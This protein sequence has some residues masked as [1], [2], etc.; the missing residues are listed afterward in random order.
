MYAL[1]GDQLRVVLVEGVGDEFDEDET[2]GDMLVFRRVHIVAEFVSGA[3]ELGFETVIGRGV[4]R[5]DK[6]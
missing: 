3:P 4:L 1:T 2:E 5:R 6:R